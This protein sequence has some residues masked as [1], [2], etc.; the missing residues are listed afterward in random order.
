MYGMMILEPQI[1]DKQLKKT[2]II[3]KPELFKIARAM[4]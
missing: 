4:L 1:S 2:K 3:G